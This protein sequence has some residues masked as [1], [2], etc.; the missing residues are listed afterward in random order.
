MKLINKLMALALV[1]CAACA[2]NKD[3]DGEGDVPTSTPKD[4]KISYAFTASSDFFELMN[5]AVEYMDTEGTLKSQSI[6][7]NWTYE[8]TVSYESAPVDYKC[9][10]TF[11]P[12]VQGLEQVKESYAIEYNFKP[13]VYKVMSDGESYPLSDISSHQ[14]KITI[15]GGEING[16]LSDLAEGLSFPFEYT[17]SK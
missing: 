17:L 11:S 9:K 3:N 6:T 10:V 16:Y 7:E 2:C 5:V 13:G 8:K 12:S 15:P 1:I 14:M 4:V